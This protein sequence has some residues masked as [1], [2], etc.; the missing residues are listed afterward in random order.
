MDVSV[1]VDGSS[2]LL[3]HPVYEKDLQRNGM[4]RGGNYLKVFFSV[5]TFSASFG[6]PGIV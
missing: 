3:F 2:F 5:F 4:E 6:I 1:E